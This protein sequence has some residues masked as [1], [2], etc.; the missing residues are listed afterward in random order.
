[1]SGPRLDLEG[2]RAPR[3]LWRLGVA[4]LGLLSIGLVCGS[5]TLAQDATAPYEHVLSP[6]PQGRS[7]G[8]GEL[9]GGEL[10]IAPF[11]P[12]DARTGLVLAAAYGP[13]PLFVL[14]GFAPDVLETTPGTVGQLITGLVG[15]AASSVAFADA[16]N[17]SG[18][19]DVSIHS[20]AAAHAMSWNAQMAT[21][22]LLELLF[23]ST[24][25]QIIDEATP[26]VVAYPLLGGAG[27]APRWIW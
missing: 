17:S 13:S 2:R 9:S 4:S 26:F 22:S 15:M 10:T 25:A 6:M 19:A 5:P 18:G 12:G 27:I 11:D 8:F 21:R 14:D 23:H 20:I 16:F 3:T 7:L 24:D 1:M